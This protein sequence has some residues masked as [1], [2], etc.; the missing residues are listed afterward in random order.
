RSWF[1]RTTDDGGQRTENQRTVIC[2]LSSVIRPPLC[3]RRLGL[4]D[5]GL[6]GR[7]L[8]DGEVGKHLAVDGDAGLAQAGDEAAVIE[9]ERA[10]R[11]VEALDPQCAERALLP[12]A[13]AEGILVRLL[14]RLLGDADGVLAPAVIALGGLEYLLVLGMGCDAAL[15]A[16]HARSPLKYAERCNAIPPQA[17]GLPSGVR[18]K[19]LFDSVAVGLEQHVGAAQLADLLL[20]ALDHA[21]AL[22]R[23][24]IEDLPGPRHLEALL[25]A[26]LG[27]D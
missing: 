21:V 19:V 3:E 25:G 7:R 18:Q 1:C 5:D 22:A 10:H 14:H 23:L 15:D 6:E 16:C 13:V 20:G 17:G 24:L 8:G 9:P 11:G 12:L 2:R 4:A 26:R 27:L